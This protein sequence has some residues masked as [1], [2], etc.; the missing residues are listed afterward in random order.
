MHSIWAGTMYKETVSVS[1]LVF[2]GILAGLDP[3]SEGWNIWL[4][5]LDSMGRLEM[6]SKAWSV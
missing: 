1:C 4:V 6:V 5:A 3:L 2:P